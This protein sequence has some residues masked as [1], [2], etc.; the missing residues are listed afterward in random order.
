MKHRRRWPEITVGVIFSILIWGTYP[1][2]SA[3]F[4]NVQ[5]SQNPPALTLKDFAGKEWKAADLYGKGI[6]VVVFWASWSP[7]STEILKDLEKL[8]QEIGPEKFQLVTVNCEHPQISAADR[9]AIA[10][11]AKDL[12][13]S[14][15]ALIDEGLVAFN[16]YGAM[17]LP[18]SL[19][20]GA[21][22]KVAFILSG[23]PSTMRTDLADAIRKAA[24]LPTST[25]VRPIVEYVPK[26]HALMYYNLGRQL[27]SKGQVEKAEEQLKISVD[28]D[29]DF[30]K[31]HLELGLLFKKTGRH[32]PAL[33]EFQRVKELDPK[34]HEA[35]YQIAV[36]SLQTGKF[37]E[38]EK[39]FHE[40]LGE[41]PEREELAL[42]LA[43][44][45]K[46]QGREEDYKKTRE[47]AAKLY[48][49][50][51]RYLYEMGGISGTQKDLPTE[52]EFYR[53]AL[54][55]ALKIAK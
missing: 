15:P 34:D 49:A 29:P 30:K 23:Y 50:E 26:N 44:A 51:P 16:D 13:L 25:D 42:G 39:L 52:A 5:V 22:G 14:G 4:K 43:L 9:D 21:D 24:G 17:A 1:T 41:F 10:K 20:V 3:A 28:R 37:P 40:L 2:L 33:Q 11:V 27:N 53:R 45:Q 12:G 7:R 19:V 32:D 36:V 31:A 35:L 47:Q 38:A 8:R 6:A 18:S 54:E 55:V 46:Y 48:P